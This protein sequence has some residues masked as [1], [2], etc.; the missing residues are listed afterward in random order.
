MTSN[1][2]LLCFELTTSEVEE[3]NRKANQ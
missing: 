2:R 1:N 3:R